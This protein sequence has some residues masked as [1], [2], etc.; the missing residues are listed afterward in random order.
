[1]H[2]GNLCEKNVTNKHIN[3]AQTLIVNR[4]AWK[5]DKWIFISEQII[6][7]SCFCMKWTHHL[8]GQAISK[9]PSTILNIAINPLAS[10]QHCTS[11]CQHTQ[12][13]ICS[14]ARFPDN[15]LFDFRCFW[16]QRLLAK[17]DVF[18]WR[19]YFLTAFVDANPSQH[20]LSSRYTG[21]LDT[22]EVF[23]SESESGKP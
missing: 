6:T 10:F 4:N 5:L 17:K 12:P 2:G 21:P 20:P 7:L 16:I 3:N 11:R 18:L 8:F 22:E 15:G 13:A 1:M 23:S 9:K 19:E 14:I